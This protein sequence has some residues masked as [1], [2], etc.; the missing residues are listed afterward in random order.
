MACKYCEDN[1]ELMFQASG[2][3]AERFTEFYIEKFYNIDTDKHS[4]LI[5]VFSG[6]DEL[7]SKYI[8]FCPMCGEP[9]THPD[10][11]G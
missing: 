10:R 11:K 8:K 2:V 7:Y 4:A 6:E 5:C 1:R 3:F 9:L